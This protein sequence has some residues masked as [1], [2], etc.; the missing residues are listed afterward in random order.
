MKKLI[1]QTSVT[2]LIGLVVL[3]G[4]LC[5]AAG[6]LD[7]WQGWLFTV[8]FLLCNAQQGIYLA[9]KDPALLARRKQVTAD[10]QSTGQKIIMFVGLGSIFGMMLVSAL[11]QRFGWSQ[12]P[13]VVSVIG[14]VLI[15]VSYYI[16]Y[17][18]FRENSYAASTVQTFE[19]QQVISTG[20]YGLV[21]HPKYVGDLF[22][23][24]GIPLALG[25][26]WGLLIALISLAGLVWRILDEEKLLRQDLPGYGEYTQKVR[27]RLVPNVW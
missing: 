7:Y 23:V 5:L 4:L 8:V 19:G 12:V 16:Y 14:L 2:S 24:G 9:V 17:R 10:A 3:G 13:A 1:V 15:V 18:V 6:T 20:M 27:Y 25:S 11:D 26:W 22:L 21:R